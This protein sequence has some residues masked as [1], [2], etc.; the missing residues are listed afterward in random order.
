MLGKS[1]AA[2]SDGEGAGKETVVGTDAFA[3]ADN[4]S[5]IR[6]ATETRL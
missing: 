5:G 1:A 2:M 6:M 4:P 3:F